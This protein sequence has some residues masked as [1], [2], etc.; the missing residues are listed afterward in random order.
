MRRHCC[1]SL[2]TLSSRPD[3]IRAIISPICSP[4]RIE[5]FRPGTLITKALLP[6]T[7]PVICFGSRRLAVAGIIDPSEAQVLPSVASEGGRLLV[8]ARLHLRVSSFCSRMCRGMVRS[9]IPVVRSFR[10]RFWLINSVVLVQFARAGFVQE[11]VKFGAVG[12]ITM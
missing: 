1:S 10:H 11:L 6:I 5:T 12:Q 4:W 8:F 7:A 9:I 3:K 2:L